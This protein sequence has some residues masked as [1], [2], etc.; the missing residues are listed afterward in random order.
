MNNFSRSLY[1]FLAI[2]ACLCTGCAS[3]YSKVV[4]FTPSTPWDSRGA[5]QLHADVNAL[6]PFEVAPGD[7]VSNKGFD[8]PSCWVCLGDNQK[9]DAFVKTLKHSPAWKVTAIS[10]VRTDCRPMFGLASE[11]GSMVDGRTVTEQNEP[12][13]A[14]RAHPTPARP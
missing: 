6:M 8:G 14:Q 13:L 7:F 1:L 10:S 2:A 5:A 9:T 3:N 11:P 4:R 12:I